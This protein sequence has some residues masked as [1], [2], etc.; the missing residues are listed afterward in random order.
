MSDSFNFS[1]DILELRKKTAKL[2]IDVVLGKISV[3]QALKSFP[4]NS[5]DLSVNTCFHILVHYEADEELRSKDKLYK[6]TQ[7]EF[8]VSVAETL[9]KGE[10]LPVNII[11]EYKVFYESDLIYKKN[12]KEN[13]IKRLR[14]IINL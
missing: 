7:D 14:R 10:S 6:E 8:V 3:L 1:Q 4:D 12:S 11:D 13:I 5:S 2:L 9:L